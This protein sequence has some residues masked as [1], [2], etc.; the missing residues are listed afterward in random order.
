MR[1][2]SSTRAARW[3]QEGPHSG[4]IN[5]RGAEDPA[6]QGAMP[7]DKQGE[8]VI[9]CMH[10]Q[11]A[12]DGEVPARSVRVPQYGPARRLPGGL[13]RRR[14]AGGEIAM[15]GGPRAMNTPA[16][17]SGRCADT[18]THAGLSSARG[19]PTIRTMM[20]WIRTATSLITFGFSVY[21]FFQIELKSAAGRPDDPR[22]ARVRDR[23]DRHRPAVDVIAWSSTRG[24]CGRC[25]ASMSDA[26]VLHSIGHDR[27]LACW[28]CSRWRPVVLRA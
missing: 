12:R 26:E 19:S 21:K 25:G 22:T 10:G 2:S 5:A 16:P 11:R 4:P 14:S 7:Q 13:D 28:G 3:N 27:R 1:R 18:A 6:E 15:A 23:L 20:A 17:G 8:M 24:T 9:A